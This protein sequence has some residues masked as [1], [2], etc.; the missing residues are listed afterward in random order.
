MF[1]LTS[2]FLAFMIV[3]N[4]YCIIK[5]LILGPY[6]KEK[7][8][9]VKLVFLVTMV[10]HMMYVVESSVFLAYGGLEKYCSDLISN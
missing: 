3:I 10:G 6:K 4:A 8:L 1:S 7:S 2:L 9:M 5:Y